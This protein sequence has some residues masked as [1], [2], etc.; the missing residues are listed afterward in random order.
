MHGCCAAS[1]QAVSGMTDAST[2]AL[3]DECIDALLAGAD[4][5]DVVPP[6]HAARAEIAELMRIAAEL[7]AADS[8]LDR[9]TRRVYRPTDG[10]NATFQGKPPQEYLLG[11][12][13]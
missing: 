5:Q 3:L 10:A 13:S 1:A 7:R 8:D 6:N 2:A 11:A 12:P 4:W 9:L